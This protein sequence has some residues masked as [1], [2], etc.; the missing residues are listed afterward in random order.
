M[1]SLLWGLLRILC[2]VSLA[3][4]MFGILS[5]FVPVSM[6]ACQ[7]SSGSIDCISPVYQKLNELGYGIVLATVFTGLPG[8]LAMG[9]IYFLVSDIRHA[10]KA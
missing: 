8:L 10:R 4:V 2:Y 5:L 6:G 1:K 3:V 9:G 7:T